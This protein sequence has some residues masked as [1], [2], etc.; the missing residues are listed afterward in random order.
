MKHLKNTT[1]VAI[2]SVKLL[3]TLKSLIYSSKNISF[4]S[5]KFLT[6]ADKEEFSFF[7]D[8]IEHVKIPEIN[9]KDEYSK[10]VLYELKNYIDTEYLITVQYDGFILNPHVWNDDWFNYDYIGAPFPPFYVSREDTSRLVRVGN[11][12]FSLR[13][14][15]F[16]NA[17]TELGLELIRDNLTGIAEDHQ[18]CCIHHESYLKYGIKFAPV[19]VAKYFSLENFTLTPEAKKQITSLGFHT[20]RGYIG[21]EKYENFFFPIFS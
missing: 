13:S 11:G 20:C 15:K 14:K 12:G 18:Q 16:I 5:I 6:S 10:F 9:D 7:P 3:P 4:K 19:E 17:F 2:S 1:L 21:E 8:Y